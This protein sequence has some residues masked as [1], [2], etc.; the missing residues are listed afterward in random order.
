MPP[1]ISAL[2]PAQ[3]PEAGGNPVVISGVGFVGVTSVRFGANNATY[4]VLSTSSIRAVAPPGVGQAIVRVT[5]PSGS[6][7]GLPYVY[8]AAPVLTALSPS[9][10][11]AVGGNQVVLTGSGFTGAS[12]VRF[13]AVS[14]VF[15]VNSATQITATA[16]AGSGSV[17]VTV[18]TPGGTSNG[19]PYVYVAAPVLTALSPSQGPA[20]GGNQVVLTG[21]GFTGA[22]VVRFGAVS[23]VFTVNSATQITATAPA[24]SGSV[25][26]TVT[27][28]GGTSNGLPYVYV[29][30]PVL[31]ALSPSQGPAVGGNQV[32]LTGTGFTGA[33]VVRF[34]AVPAVF[35]VNSATQI[36]A[37]APAGSGS[38]SVT[39]TTPGGTSNGLPYV[40]VA[41]PVLTA[42]SPPQGPEAGGNQVVLTGTGFTGATVV[43]FGAVPAVFTVNSATQIT[44]TAPAGSGSVSVTVTTPGG[45]SNGLPYVYVA[46]PVLYSLVPGQGPE[47]GGN[48]VVLTGTGFTGATVVR[49]GA[50]PAVFTVNSATQIT[51]TAPAG[52]GSVAVTVT[53]PSGTSNS[54]TYAYTVTPAPTLTDLDPHFGPTG[55]GNTVTIFGTNL[56]GT[57]A[58]NF[59]GQLA[60]S[61]VVVSANQVTATAPPGTG[62]VVVTVTNPGGTS[63]PNIGNPYYTY[64]AQPALTSLVPDTGPATG[65]TGVTITGT[66]LTYTEQV[67]FG[68]T[69]A[70]FAA[71]SDNIVLATSPP[72]AGS[73]PVTVQT[74]G[75]TS[76]SLTFT[77]Q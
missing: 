52:V 9:Q 64:V 25:S 3:G 7:N 43:R 40:Y 50:V 66:E 71:V 44:A 46:A 21:S 30:A 8:V 12:V 53:T 63:D 75:G 41:A 24:G 11:P 35:T 73:V 42:L 16:P 72:G 26:V 29:A 48:Q 74:P 23:A 61:V 36:T 45:T 77:Y 10:G 51:A 32:V 1:V 14:A 38:V 18:T 62:T 34:G 15:T 57:T 49:F 33:T 58:V 69:P 6:S 39:V 19:L 20:V 68:A 28:P 67:F 70:S 13:G 55:G 17:S 5:A 65:G 27:T 76:N 4:T 31:T 59:D 47:A 37:T 60:G 22:S 56:T 54:V 2:N